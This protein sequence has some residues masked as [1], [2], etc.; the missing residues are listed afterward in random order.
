MAT[1]IKF[2]VNQLGFESPQ[3]M[4]LTANITIILCAVI[5]F[6]VSPMP[7]DWI[8]ET[9]KVYILTVTSSIGGMFK[10]L[11]KLTGIHDVYEKPEDE[12]EYP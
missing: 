7:N 1:K 11:E 9:V 5:A 3:W 12:P 8:S 4:K 6:I 2:G 10:G